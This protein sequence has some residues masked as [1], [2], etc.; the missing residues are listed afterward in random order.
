M[1]RRKTEFGFGNQI[2]FSVAKRADVGFLHCMARY[3]LSTLDLLPFT[4]IHCPSLKLK[5]LLKEKKT[6]IGKQIMRH[7][8]TI[9]HWYDDD[10]C[11]CIVFVTEPVRKDYLVNPFHFI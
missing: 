1:E 5:G 6:K 7:P 3:L 8:N 2:L 10:K 4:D 9:L 11:I